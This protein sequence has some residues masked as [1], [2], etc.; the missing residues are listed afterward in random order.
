MAIAGQ[1]FGIVG[2]LSAFPRRLVAREVERQFGH[3]RRG[4]TRQTTYLVF[5]RNLL[6]KSSEAEIEARF[7]AEHA[8]GRWLVSENG[9]LRLLGLM[10]VPVASAL[11]RQSLIDQAKL[12]PR[13]FDLLSLF[14]AFEHDS[15]PFSFRDL[16]LARKYA[17]LIGS[18]ANWSAIV[19]SV[20]RSGQVASLTALSL[21]SGG[22][23][24]IYARSAEGLS[25]LNG[26]LLFDLGAP[27]DA[28][29]E[30]LFD[31]AEEAEANGDYEE[32]ATFYQRYLA[33]DRTDSVAA[34][35][36]AN[37]LKAA[38]RELDAA[39]D[40]ARAIKLDPSF[41]EAWFNL[42]GL[43]SERGRIDAA[44]R[45]LKKAIELDGDYADAVFNLAKLEFD[46]GDLGEARRWWSRYLE[47]DSD[48]EWARTAE[49]GVQYVDLQG[50]PR[51]TG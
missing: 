48:S 33:M 11:T 9:F 44:R 8:A 41:V 49:R 51:T 6:A 24:A 25:E 40:Y 4:V 20:H 35:N 29:L 22:P 19:R 14:D 12:S 3:L 1:T 16:I 26:Q 45:H 32:A 15:E 42:A 50:R 36:R 2:G 7:D 17:E 28:A 30:D 37:C 18:G 10:S 38:G 47:L 23:D 34:F 27:D 43:M 21:H 13:T 46:A 31:L 5:G 39:H